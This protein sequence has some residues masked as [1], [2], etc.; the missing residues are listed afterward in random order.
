M[1]ACALFN[2]NPG[3]LIELSLRTLQLDADSALTCYIG[4]FVRA[5]RWKVHCAKFAQRARIC[6]LTG[7]AAPSHLQASR[8]VSLTPPFNR[9]EGACQSTPGYLANLG[10]TQPKY[11]AKCNPTD[12]KFKI[13]IHS[14]FKEER[15]HCQVEL[16]IRP[17]SSDSLFP[18]LS[19]VSRIRLHSSE[20]QGIYAIVA[21]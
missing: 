12:C 8:G 20:L 14:V 10:I 9:L 19:R 15:H 5:C 6:C 18:C 3:L 21:E 17:N 11:L 7:A 2:Q 16:T 1:S 13:C 4:I